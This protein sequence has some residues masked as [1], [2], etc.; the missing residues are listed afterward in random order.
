MKMHD[1][2]LPSDLQFIEEPPVPFT[3]HRLDSNGEIHFQLTFGV[4]D[5]LQFYDFTRTGLMQTLSNNPNITRLFGEESEDTRSAGW[6]SFEG[7]TADGIY[8]IEDT[9]MVRLIEQS[10]KHLSLDFTGNKIDGIW[11]IRRIPRIFDLKV[12]ANNR[13][14][15]FWK[16]GDVNPEAVKLSDLDVSKNSELNG[17]FNLDMTI[18][19][20]EQTFEGIAAASGTWTDM[21]GVPYLYTDEFIEQMSKEQIAKLAAGEKIPLNTEHPEDDLAIDGEVTEVLLVREPINH[22]RVKGKYHGAMS[23]NKSEIGLSYEFRFRSLWNDE[24]QAWIPFDNITDK[25][26]VVKRPACKI[27]WITKVIK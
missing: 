20:E 24:F 26:S 7:N 5:K 6:L 9:G 11:I 8:S 2:T 1:P 18:N 23:L 17:R 4:G 19:E 25:L 16:P 27:C 22:I 13:G 21:F 15:L 14:V 12:F 3:I 10:E